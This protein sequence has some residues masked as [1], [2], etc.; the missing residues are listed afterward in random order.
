MVYNLN[1]EQKKGDQPCSI[2]LSKGYGATSI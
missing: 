2:A 1:I